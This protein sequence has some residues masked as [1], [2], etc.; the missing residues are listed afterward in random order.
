VNDPADQP[1]NMLGR[2]QDRFL[3]GQSETLVVGVYI[4][5]EAVL[6]DDSAWHAPIASWRA[7]KPDAPPC[8]RPL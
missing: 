1:T 8:R 2:G 4:V 3:S 6:Q 7:S 5:F